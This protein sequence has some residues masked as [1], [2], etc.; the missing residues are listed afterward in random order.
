[1]PSTIAV[2]S[3]LLG[4]LTV[5][6]SAVITFPHGL[7]GFPEC[8]SFILLPSERE[9]VYWLQSMDYSTLAFLMVDPFIFFDGYTVDLAATDIVHSVTSPDDVTVLAI[10]T[11]PQRRS[12]K[13]TANLQGPVV[14][15]TRSCEG[16]QVVLADGR[17][18]IRETFDL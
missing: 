16:H 4:T 13:S 2:V 18:A 3:D 11:L 8:R 1:M 12:E 10:V 6:P 15:N 7:L 9:H 17:Y 14:I 5:Q